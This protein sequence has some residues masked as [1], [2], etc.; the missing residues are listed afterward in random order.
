MEF[1]THDEACH[2][3]ASKAKGN[4]ALT[5]GIIGTSLAALNSNGCGNNGIL[6]GI[7]G[8]NNNNCLAQKAMDMAMLQGQQADNLSWSNRVQSMEDDAKLFFDVNNR[9]NSNVNEMY[10]GRIQDLQEKSSMYIDLISRDNANAI[11]ITKEMANGRE[12]DIK[13]KSDIYDRL[14]SKI[15]DLEKREI[16]TAT[17]LPL[18]FELASVKANKYTD[19]S[20]C[21]AEKDFLITTG[22]LQRQLDH[23]INGHLK[24]AYSDLCAPVPDISPLYCSP[25]TPFG[26]GMYAGEAANAYN[27]IMTA[28][29]KT[30]C[31]NCITQ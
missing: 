5:L 10:Q 13:E 6:G 17:A 28:Y 2:K 11:A 27:N 23:K 22:G 29:N 26:I 7:L 24:Y 4:A 30:A 20:Y 1:L 3:F 21:K 8:G 25:F 14:I 16:A 18:M 15:N 9:I 31:R 19:D 12:V